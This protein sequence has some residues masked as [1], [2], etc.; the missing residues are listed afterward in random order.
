MSRN[1]TIRLA[2]A[3]I[4]IV[5]FSTPIAARVIGIT[6]ESFENRPFA[7]A[8]KLSQGWDAFGQTTQFLVDRM[9][10]RK[11]AVEANTRIWTDIFD[12]TPRY[13]GPTTPG[14]DGPLPAGDPAQAAGE[15]EQVVDTA[16][17]VLS[18]RD[19]W[20]FV[21]AEMN[22]ACGPPL[23]FG[24]AI[25]RWQTLI[26][27]IRATGRRALLVVAPDKG[28]I[29]P[30]HLDDFPTRACAASGKRDFWGQ[31]E[32]AERPDRLISLRDDLLRLKREA[33]EDGDD[34]Y[35][36]KDSHWTTAG[37]LALVRAMLE[38]I[39]EPGARLR[40]SEIVDPG[41][42]E[43]T[44]DLTNLLGAPETDT[45]AQR[46]IQRAAGAKV[47]PGRTLM[48]GDSYSQGPAPQLA[49][50][51]EDLRGAAWVGTPPAKLAREI[52]AADLVLLETVERE[53]THRAVDPVPQVTR[54]LQ[55]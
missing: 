44:G 1:H 45:Q 52:R 9:P 24:E 34:L 29:Y 11:Q 25:A 31:L 55:R 16:A 38:G 17:Q 46:T 54:Q 47:I 41:R 7:T 20:L 3:V 13:G 10:L 42:T 37:S 39:G 8:P 28:S 4:A 53:L 22:T 23:P 40:E 15:Q 6:A 30:E 32:R 50:Y 33:G 12:T 36:R 51:F 2:F 14:Q 26:D 48:I 49:P 35:A 21:H 5:F 18:G 19:G 43:Y 27:T